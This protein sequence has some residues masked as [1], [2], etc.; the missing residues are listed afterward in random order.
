MLTV[1]LRIPPDPNPNTIAPNLT[2]PSHFP[3][4]SRAPQ[5]PSQKSSSQYK[6]PQIPSKE[7]SDNGPQNVGKNSRKDDSQME[8]C[9][10]ALDSSLRNLAKLG[11]E[12]LAKFV[13]VT[14]GEKSQNSYR[15][16]LDNKSNQRQRV[17][18]QPRTFEVVN[19]KPVVVF[20]E[21]ENELLAQT[22][23]L[24]SL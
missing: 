9:D 3:P 4:L 24:L 7:S 18:L 21:E 6:N 12:S 16:I 1:D 14:N 22:L 15:N 8:E 5:I 20:T 13:N 2:S 19:G 10:G 23:L 11:I 17:K